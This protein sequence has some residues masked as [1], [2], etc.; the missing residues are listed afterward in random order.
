MTD[1]QVFQLVGLAY[2]AAGLGMLINSKFYRRMIDQMLD[3]PP[4]I[5]L[6]GFMALAV[7][8]LL[9]SFYGSRHADLRL[10]LTIIGW[11]AL[12]KGLTSI[13][14]P[15]LLIKISRGFMRSDKAVAGAGLVMTVLGIAMLYIGFMVIT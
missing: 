10:I 8:Y 14:Q 4:I 11:L 15:Q 7:G 6:S 1:A 13:I 3:S 9:I 5:Y 12:I 2:L